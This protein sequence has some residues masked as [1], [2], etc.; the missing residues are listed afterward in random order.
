MSDVLFVTWDGGGNLPPALGIARELLRRGDVPRFLGHS[1]Q[2]AAVE[3]AGIAFESFSRGRPWD[4]SKPRSTPA[5]LMGLTG[6]FTDKG[7]AQDAVESAAR[8]R[9]DVVVV[10][11][12][13]FRALKA[14]TAA[15]LTTVSLV[16]T[17]QHYLDRSTARGP[18]A[19]LSTLRGVRPKAAWAAADLRLVC[20]LPQLDRAPSESCAEKTVQI[21]PVWQ[22][23]PAPAAAVAGRPRVLVSMSTCWFPGQLETLQTVLDAV[24]SLPVDVVVTTGPAT[25]PARLRP[26]VNTEVRAYVDHAELMPRMS[27]VVGHGGHS[28]AMRALSYDLPLL[29]LPMHPLLDQ[30]MVGEAIA[31]FGAGRVLARKSSSADIA[32][33]I[34]ELVEDGPHRLAAARLGAAIRERDGAVAA[35]DRISAFVPSG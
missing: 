35:A 34:T 8:Q 12:L 24:G 3:S 27:M 31:G 20:A 14:V 5:A 19:I 21:G 33:A 13:L 32:T 26:A 22:G 9:T 11:C 16:H 18:V 25:D 30:A 6:I 7:I 2:R 17:F 10:D 23:D 15:G 29:I 28:T 4:S 1:T